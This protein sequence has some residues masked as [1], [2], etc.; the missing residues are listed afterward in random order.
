MRESIKRKLDQIDDIYP[1][2]RLAKSKERWRRL[3]AG[4]QPLDR[5]PFCFAPM[6]IDYYT[7]SP[8]EERLDL[9]LDHAIAR[10]IVE[11]DFIPSFFPG[12]SQATLPTLFGAVEKIVE[13]DYTCDHILS[14]YEDIA[15]LP[16]PRVIPG[17]RAAY[18]LELDEWILEETQGRLP[19]H[20]MDSQGPVDVAGQL[21]GYDQLFIAAYEAPELYEQLLNA[22]TDAFIL[23]WNKQKELLG[24]RF[25]PTHLFGWDWLPPEFGAT[26]SVDSLVMV[27][28]RFY[29]AYFRPYLE[30]ISDAFGGV[31]VHSC[32]NFSQVV[33]SLLKTRTMRGVN[34]S[35]LTVEQLAAAGI[36]GSVV[37][38]A[39]TEVA[40]LAQSIGFVREN[41]LRL[42]TAVHGI[43]PNC[44]NGPK[45]ADGW[46]AADIQG[47][48]R[49]NAS[50]LEILSC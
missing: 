8:R 21:L 13:A 10:G 38:I 40:S 37:V 47:I 28:P 43:W 32:G 26:V 33:P 16:E 22:I 3:W 30:Q 42:N 27:L 2:E 36:D 17:T 7:I 23:F 31:T 44:A 19:V 6:G 39:P 14:S 48:K 45:S 29:D 11:D 20:V 18:F 49:A 41:G 9:Y 1:A 4:E 12:C 24:D 50:V 46:S 34:A 35:Q 25:V 15:R 5:L